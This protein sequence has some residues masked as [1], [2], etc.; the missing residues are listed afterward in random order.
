MSKVLCEENIFLNLESISKEEAI[1]LTGRKLVENGY[2][3]ESYIDAMLEREKVMTTYIG[4]GFAIPHGISDSK[5]E[6]K[7]S[8]LVILQFPNGIEFEDGTAYILIGIAGIGDEHIDILSKVA[9]L[10]DDELCDRLRVE[11]D[12]SEF[13]RTFA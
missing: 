13:M 6:I 3:S 4:M 9:I 7:K 10:I 1:K 11:Q 5:K 8:G 2:T 12:K